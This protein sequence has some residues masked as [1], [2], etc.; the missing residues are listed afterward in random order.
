MSR[1]S[2]RARKLNPQRFRASIR[3]TLT[4]SDWCEAE[5]HTVRAY[6][7]VL[8]MCRKLPA[9]GYDQAMP[10]EAY[11]GDTLCLKVRSIGEGANLEINGDGVGLR[12]RRKP[13][14]AS[15]IAPNASRGSV[16]RLA[17]SNAPQALRTGRRSR[18]KGARAER[19]LVRFLQG[20]GF[21]AEKIS[22]MYKP[23]ADINLPLLGRDRRVEVKVRGTGFRQLYAWLD[24][25]DLLIVRADR[26]EP[27]VILPLRLGAQIAK[28]A[29][30]GKAG[31]S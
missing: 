28:A 5:G 6:A 11:R 27:L 16:M 24:C 19:A 9:A 21:A 18:D 1:E 7:P 12:Q 30:R 25:R 26:R 14:A 13:D 10:L 20:R 3:A 29:E 4:G 8:A 22:G 15:V 2:A 17:V 23:G 31:A